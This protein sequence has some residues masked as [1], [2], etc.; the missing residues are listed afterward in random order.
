MNNTPFPTV[1]NSQELGKL[2]ELPFL[3]AKPTNWW[4]KSIDGDE[5]V[6]KTS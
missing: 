6:N 4:E 2:A 1:S 5:N 3:N